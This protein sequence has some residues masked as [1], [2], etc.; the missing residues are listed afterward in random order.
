MENNVKDEMD[1]SELLK[2]PLRLFGY[3]YPYF[4]TIGVGIGILY[5]RNLNYVERNSVKPVVTLDTA[6]VNDIP[7]T[8][9][10]NIP[11]VDVMKV[12]IPTKELIAKGEASY[13][14]NC[15]SCHGDNGMG[16]GPSAATMNPKPRNFHSKDGWTNGRKISQMYK[17]LEEGIVKN[18]M[19]SYNYLPAEDRFA[20]IHYVRTFNTDF[21]VDS[22]SELMELEKTYQLSKG[23]V[24]AAKIPVKIAMQKVVQ[25]AQPKINEVAAEIEE[26]KNNSLLDMVSANKHRVMISLSSPTL[27]GKSFDEFVKMISENPVQLGFKATT[28]NSLSMGDWEKLYKYVGSLKKG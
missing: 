22:T 14:A 19:A 23:S 13:K 2:N 11:P 18:G 17:T 25:D 6:M 27:Q 4:L 12:S 8:P 26:S 16:D 1:F 20:L 24:T 15:V 10:R 7:M 5:I 9:A 21:P 28:I 3:I